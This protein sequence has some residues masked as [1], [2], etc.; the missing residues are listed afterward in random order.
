MA[1]NFI[2]TKFSGGKARA[3]KNF[4]L[5]FFYLPERIFSEINFRIFAEKVRILFE[6]DS[7]IYFECGAEKWNLIKFYKD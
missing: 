7:K 2:G 3:G 6:T 5:I 1:A 4:F